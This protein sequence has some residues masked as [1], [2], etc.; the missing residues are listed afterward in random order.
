MR[1]FQLL[2]TAVFWGMPMDIDPFM[3]LELDPGYSSLLV[4]QGDTGTA[5]SKSIR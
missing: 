5:C 4:S 1:Q 2:F 3:R